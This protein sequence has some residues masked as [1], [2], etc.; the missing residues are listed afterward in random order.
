MPKVRLE[1]LRAGMVVTAEIKNMDDM[2]LIPA[3]C[4]LTDNHIETLSAWGIADAQVESSD[5][6]PE[7]ADILATLAPET[8]EALT[9]EVKA[10]FWDPIDK[11][12]VQAETFTLALRRE[13]R[14]FKTS[15]N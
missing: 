9:N 5:D 15:T 12:A 4:T 11:N 7:P 2:L 8:L 10:R 3:G 6:S 13:A 1:S 14:R